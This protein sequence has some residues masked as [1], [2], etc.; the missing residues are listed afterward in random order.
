MTQGDAANAPVGR[1][2]LL[3]VEIG[4]GLA[5]LA[6]VLFHANASA[7]EF[8]GPQWRWPTVL[9]HGVDFFFVL[10]GFIILYAHRRHLGRP[11]AIGPYLRKR[12]IRL[13]PLLWFVVGGWAIIR[14]LGGVPPD[15]A[16]LIR[17]LLPYPSLEE[18]MPDVVWTLRHEM[19]FYA[20]FVLLL[21]SRR[22]GMIVMTLWLLATLA[23]FGAVLAGRPVTG[24]GSFFLSGYTVDFMLGMAMAVIVANR[25]QK[26]ALWPL[27][28]GLAFL[29]L[30]EVALW[31]FDL[32]R[33]STFDYS[34]IGATYGT[35]LLGVPLAAT[36]YGL[37]RLEG[38]F[39]PPRMLVVLGMASYA[40]YLVHTP[41]NSIMQRAA[42]YL[43]DVLKHLGVGHLILA[44]AGT[45]AGIMIHFGY[46]R[47]VTRALRRRIIGYRTSKNAEK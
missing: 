26:P 20:L 44:I 28:A 35:A 5:A 18:T 22:I 8:G 11:S 15:A 17:S 16:L 1:A 27:M 14:A 38:R 13:F 29:V 9:A 23:Q 32:N 19:F 45:V 31:R 36:L 46:E 12:A 40:I 30:V 24:I 39:T 33:Q 34:S 37:V 21:W 4:R 6:V 47:P 42:V 3:Y 25:P 10:S 7:I 43:P 2:K 41:V